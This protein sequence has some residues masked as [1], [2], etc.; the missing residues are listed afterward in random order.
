MGIQQLR[1]GFNILECLEWIFRILD[2][3]R[4]LFFILT[5][6]QIAPKHHSQKFC[7]ETGR[8]LDDNKHGGFFYSYILLL[9]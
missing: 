4:H 2:E 7:C 5:V 6:F 8:I 9:I 3:K 1:W